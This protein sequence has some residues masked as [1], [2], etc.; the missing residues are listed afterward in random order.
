MDKR[1]DKIPGVN[2][3]DNKTVFRKSVYIGAIIANLILVY[4]FN[5][6]LNWHVP[7]LTE[8]FL[9]VLS[10]LNLSIIGT[11]IANIFFLF[12]DSIWF[13]NLV[14][15]ALNIIGVV[16]LAAFYKIFPFDFSSIPNSQLVEA[17]VKVG[18]FLGV[19]VL[20][21]VVIVEIFRLVRHPFKK[22]SF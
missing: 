22:I 21:I 17:S 19:F 11:I 15:I 20:S 8:E 1:V 3:I 14:R 7:F 16:F 6:L 9:D 2:N 10:I 4:L 12:Y 5:N 13:Q 18:L